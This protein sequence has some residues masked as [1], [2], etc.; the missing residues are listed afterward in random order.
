MKKSLGRAFI[1]SF[2]VFILL[3]FLFYIIGYS[4]AG[5]V[6]IVLDRIAAHP[7]HAIY[8]MVNPAQYFPWEILSLFSSTGIL[9]FQIR[10][11]GGFISYILAA[12]IAGLM[13]GDIGKSFGGWILSVIC[14][15][16]LF[17][18]IMGVDDYNLSYISFTSTF[19]E[20][21]VVVAIASAV[22]A[23]IFGALVILIAL[24]KGKS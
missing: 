20:G 12:I 17:I 14:S 21:I 13:G 10:Y 4:I 15:I 1:F 16:V 11:L 8:L 24:L 18:V 2:L 9:G 19:V 5:M 22:N 3:N 6:D 23:L 7:S